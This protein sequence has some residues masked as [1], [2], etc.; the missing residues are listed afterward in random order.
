MNFQL[1]EETGLFEEKT[2]GKQINNSEGSGSQIVE[3]MNNAPELPNKPRARKAMV[4]RDQN[5]LSNLNLNEEPTEVQLRESRIAKNRKITNTNS[6]SEG[7][8]VNLEGGNEWRS[9]LR[10][11]WDEE[12]SSMAPSKQAWYKQDF[13]TRS[14]TPLR[15]KIN[16]T[17]VDKER[18]KAK[19]FFFLLNN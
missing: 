9:A 5:L 15:K 7:F 1:N 19:V 4:I 3:S 11:A 18:Q 17:T 16:L 8:A 12:I 14:L 2:R 10:N 6:V 13:T